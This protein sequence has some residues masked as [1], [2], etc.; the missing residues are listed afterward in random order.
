MSDAA[1]GRR[2]RVLSH[3]A[4]AC[5]LCGATFAIYL[6]VAGIEH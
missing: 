4:V 5:L 6:D 2:G 3:L 1:A